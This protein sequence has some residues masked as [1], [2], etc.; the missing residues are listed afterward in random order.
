MD[1]SKIVSQ[2]EQA[3]SDVL[4]R[5]VAGLPE[6]TRLF[7]DLHVDSTS[8]LELLMALEDGVGI[9][10]DP[11]RLEIADFKTIGTVADYVIV[12]LDERA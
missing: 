11:E 8:V 9:E 12:N 1:R 6:E 7:E 10:V 2:I 4:Q 3:L 5:P